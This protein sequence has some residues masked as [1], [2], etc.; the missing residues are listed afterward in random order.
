MRVHRLFATATAF[1]LSYALA[2]CPIAF[3]EHAHQHV[4]CEADTN[5]KSAANFPNG[6][7][8]LIIV[9]KKA[10]GGTD[11]AARGLAKLMSEDL[12]VK[13]HVE[14]EPCH[15]GLVATKGNFYKSKT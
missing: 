13:I 10:G 11:I 3:A 6:Q 4:S 12:G 9:P 7:D 2:F 14:N 8:I 5:A 15:S 1:M